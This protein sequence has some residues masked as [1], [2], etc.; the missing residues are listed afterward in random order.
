MSRDPNNK[1]TAPAALSDHQRVG[2]RFIPPLL[3]LGSFQDAEWTQTIV[4]ECI[5]IALVQMRYGLQEGTALSLALAKAANH[6]APATPRMLFARASSFLSLGPAQLRMVVDRLDAG[7]DL[8]RLRVVLRSLIALY[9]QCPLRFLFRG[10]AIESDASGES[11]SGVKEALESVLDRHTDSATFVQATIVY[12]A[13]VTGKLKATHGTALADFPEIERYPA[14]EESQR[15]A[16]SVRGTVS[17]LFAQANTEYPSDWPRYFW[18]R[19]LE[20]E[21]CQTAKGSP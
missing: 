1:K 8:S 19:G 18:N 20:L 9:P 6:A 17:V 4:P 2:K 12:I 11:T 5:W 7:G 10:P 13:F 15:V 14:T 16:S 21:P 3:Q